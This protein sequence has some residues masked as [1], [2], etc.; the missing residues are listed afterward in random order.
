[1]NIKLI[2]FVSKIKI[3]NKNT[4]ILRTHAIHILSV[5]SI[6]SLFMLYFLVQSVGVYNLIKN[7]LNTFNKPYDK[8]Y[9]K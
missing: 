9:S 1:V 2:N 7:Y 3:E 8:Q 6:E 4:G 5:N